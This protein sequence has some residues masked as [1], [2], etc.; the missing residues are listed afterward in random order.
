MD[1]TVREA[2]DDAAKR[3][4][5]ELSDLP[6]VRAD[7]HY[8]IGEVYKTHGDYEASNQHMRQSLEL[9]REAFGEQHPKV[10]RGI[11]YV[12]MAMKGGGS[13]I[14]EVKTF[15]RNGIVMMRQTDPENLNLPYMLQLLAHCD[16]ESEPHPSESRLAE[17]ERL[18][19]E[20]KSLYTRHYG[21]EHIS[22]IAADRSLANLALKRG[23]LKKAEEMWE[24]IVER[25]RKAENGGDA[26]IWALCSFGGVKLAQRK[27]KE[28]EKLFGQALDRGRTE[29]GAKDP[30]FE[31]LVKEIGQARGTVSRNGR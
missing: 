6:E 27:E 19:L 11:Y 7:L 10:A 5:T 16:M 8:T 23:D 24:E 22:T 20:A 29:W 21:K 30:Q 3:I 13:D 1:V 28:A 26:H 2:I 12:A 25:F 31:S 15:L 18:L 4:D 17:D 9:Y 14:E